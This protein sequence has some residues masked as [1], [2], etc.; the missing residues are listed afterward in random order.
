M[1]QLK[2]GRQPIKAG[3]WLLAPLVSSSILLT[4]MANTGGVNSSESGFYFETLALEF[5]QQ[6]VLVL[7]QFYLL[8]LVL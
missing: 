2:L 4:P 6:Q 7:N 3:N 1:Y 5:L 8:V